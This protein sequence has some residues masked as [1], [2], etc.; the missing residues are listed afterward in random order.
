M[1]TKTAK[2]VHTEA[3]Q[4]GA[5]VIDS[6]MTKDMQ[7][8]DIDKLVPYA[9]NART[10]SPEQIAKLRSSLR[11]FGFDNPIIIDEKYGVPCGHGRL[12]AA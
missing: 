7:L 2:N 12:E 9:N 4:T 10:H 8:V 3:G 11:E 5:V 6:K 1:S